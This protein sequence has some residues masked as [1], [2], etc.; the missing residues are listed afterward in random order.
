[1]CAEQSG[2]EEFVAFW[3]FTP[4]KFR[5]EETIPEEHCFFSAPEEKEEESWMAEPGC[6]QANAG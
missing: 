1:M 6:D 4:T 3:L 5:K 2:V